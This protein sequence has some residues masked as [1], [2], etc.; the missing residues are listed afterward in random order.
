M[1]ASVSIKA[2]FLVDGNTSESLRFLDEE[3]VRIPH[4]EDCVRQAEEDQVG[5]IAMGEWGLSFR[6]IGAEFLSKGIFELQ[7]LLTF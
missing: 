6:L 5:K 2:Q 4:F 3:A 7:V 1:P